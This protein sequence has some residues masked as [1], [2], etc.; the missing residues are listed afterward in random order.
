LTNGTVKFAN[1]ENLTIISI[2][3]HAYI[4]VK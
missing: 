3:R 4:V 2:S 1:G